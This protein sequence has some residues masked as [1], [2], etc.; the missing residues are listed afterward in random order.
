VTDIRTGPAPTDPAA[1]TGQRG[2]LEEQ[3][4][5]LFEHIRLQEQQREAARERT[6]RRRAGDPLRTIWLERN[7]RVASIDIEPTGRAAAGHH[8]TTRRRRDPPD[9]DPLLGHRV[10]LHRAA[11]R[12]HEGRRRRAAGRPHRPRHV[13]SGDV[14]WVDLAATLPAGEPRRTNRDI[15][16][17]FGGWNRA[18]TH[19]HHCRRQQRLQGGMDLDRGR[20]DRRAHAGRARPRRGVGRRA[21]QITLCNGWLP[22]GSVYFVSERDGH[23]HLYTCAPTGPACAS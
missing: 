22:D 17:R 14:R 6:E 1:A 23:A 11:R 4:R 20:G 2:F 21:L 19:G 7:E 5:A 10:G 18:G 12:A 9:R 13:A 16:A 8:R 15:S 3:Q